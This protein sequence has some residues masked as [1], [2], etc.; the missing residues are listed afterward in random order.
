M[1]H[2]DMFQRVEFQNIILACMIFLIIYSHNVYVLYYQCYWGTLYN[3]IS[4][5]YEWYASLFIFFQGWPGFNNKIGS[6]VIISHVPSLYTLTN[7]RLNIYAF[8]TVFIVMKKV[9]SNTFHCQWKKCLLRKLVSTEIFFF[10][11]IY[12]KNQ[13][14][15][16]V[17]R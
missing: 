2:I 14:H 8:E 5:L 3:C 9:S 12:S 7:F 1:D 11:K 6:C 17:T 15:N 4:V 13:T 10:E 16:R